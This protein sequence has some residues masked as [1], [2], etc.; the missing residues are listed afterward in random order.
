ME[1]QHGSRIRPQRL[2]R[3]DQPRPARLT[4]DVDQRPIEGTPVIL[5]YPL[6]HTRLT[7]DDNAVGIAT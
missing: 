3:E 7:G 6:R 5:R 2:R 4:I 1:K